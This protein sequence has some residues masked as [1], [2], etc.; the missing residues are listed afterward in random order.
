MFVIN[1]NYT[2]LVQMSHS[3][4]IRNV[5]NMCMKHLTDE[6]IKIKELLRNHTEGMSITEI[7][8]ELK[9]NKHSIGRY[10]D[11]LHASG[12]VDLRNYGMAKVYTLSSRV[13]VSALL[14]YTMALV[15]VLDRDQRI[16]QINEPF[17]KLLDLT[18][19]VVMI[20]SLSHLPIA[21]PAVG[22]LIRQLDE[23]TRAQ[24]GE[25]R[26]EQ[27]ESVPL[28]LDTEPKQ[29]YH[30]KIV[31]TVFDNGTAGTTIILEDIS[32]KYTAV[33]A[34][35]ENE[36]LFRSVSEN[37]SDG[38]IVIEGDTII[39]MNYRLSE[40]IGYS[41]EEIQTKN[42]PDI[43]MHGEKERVQFVEE[44]ISS[45][46]QMASD[47][48]FWA[49]HK[50]G[51][52]R[53]LYVRITRVPVEDAVVRYYVLVTDMTEWKIKEEEQSIHYSLIQQLMSNFPHPIYILDGENRFFSVND[54]FVRLF[55]LQKQ[56]ILQKSIYEVLPEQPALLLSNLTTD[57]VSD[58]KNVSPPY[59][60]LS[61]NDKER[62]CHIEKNQ[63]TMS[64]QGETYMVGIIIECTDTG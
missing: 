7:A 60:F 64:L 57:Q 25:R 27:N 2:Y 62:Q 31:P 37:I 63:I 50:D 41:K 45:G 24:N 43:A 20:K 35:Q 38:L 13:P 5:Y 54:S 26:E 11:V 46:R 29:Y 42:I 14:S 52:P 1:N 22:E 36:A 16:M 39:Y 28:L 23:L 32:E 9:K 30:C 6:F 53:Y 10:L 56:E 8:R 17:L 58:V 61:F 44:S 59:V 49:E 47:I 12:H 4:N 40:I 48:Q 15:L 18:Q 51:N 33:L 3:L 19:D 55:E 21:D 34:L